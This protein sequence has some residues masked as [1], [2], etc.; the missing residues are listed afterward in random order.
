KLN[1][2]FHCAWLQVLKL[3]PSCAKKEF[4]SS[5]FA[6]V[7]IKRH[8]QFGPL[9]GERI[10]EA[11]ISEDTDLKDVWEVP[12]SQ[13]KYFVRTHS[14]NTSNWIRYLRPAPSRA[15][16]S[17]VAVT[18]NDHLFFVT[19][20]DLE[21][22]EEL[23]YWIDYPDVDITKKR[24]VDRA[25]CGTCNRS[26]LSPMYYRTHISI[27]HD[28]EYPLN[29]RKYHCKVC[30]EQVVGK[31]N[32][33]KHAEKLHDGKGAY[34]CQ[35]CGRF[36][37]R[38]SYLDVHRTYGCKNNPQRTRPL[39]DLCGKKFSQPQK[40]RTHV[41]RMHGD[42]AD[43][44][45]Q[46]QCKQ[47]SKLLGSGPALLRH[48]K[49][50]HKR[51]ID[52]SH[53]CEKCGK[54]FTNTSNL[55]IHMLTH[56]GIRPFLCKLKDC[57][58][59]FT[60]K[61]CLQQHYRKTHKLATSE[62]PPIDRVIPFTLDAY[63]GEGPEEGNVP[64]KSEPTMDDKEPLRGG[65]YPEPPLRAQ[66]PLPAFCR[67]EDNALRK[68]QPSASSL[69][70]YIA[71]YSSS[72]L[73]NKMKWPSMM[74]QAHSFAPAP[75]ASSTSGSE[76]HMAPTP[77]SSGRGST[78]DVYAF[79]EE[80]VDV[81]G[82]GPYQQ[83]ES[84]L[85]PQDDR[86]QTA[87]GASDSAM[88]DNTSMLIEAAL[89]AAG[90]SYP[91]TDAPNLRHN[92]DDRSSVVSADSGRFSSPS[93][94]FNNN[95]STPSSTSTSS[96]LSHSS[97]STESLLQAKEPTS[98]PDPC[99]VVDMR[100][101]PYLSDN[102]YSS[103]GDPKPAYITA[104]HSPSPHQDLPPLPSLSS[105][106]AENVL[107]GLGGSSDLSSNGHLHRPPEEPS[108]SSVPSSGI[109]EY[110]EDLRRHH[111]SRLSYEDPLKSLSSAFN[112]GLDL[113]RVSHHPSSYPFHPSLSS[114]ARYDAHRQYDL[115]TRT[116][117]AAY[118]MLRATA[119]DPTYSQRFPPYASHQHSSTRIDP[120]GTD[121]NTPRD[122]TLN[123]RSPPGR[124]PASPWGM[125]QTWDASRLG[126]SSPFS[127]THSSI[128]SMSPSLEQSRMNAAAAYSS[129]SPYSAPA[130][131]RTNPGPT[132][133][134][135]TGYY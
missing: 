75:E 125:H 31:E 112:P 58:K 51:N 61:Q 57:P 118:D 121:L 117:S 131:A 32:I 104:M 64:S 18:K 82:R 24:K 40:L 129:Y 60:T 88:N 30:S 33:I 92:G 134:Y 85:Q 50:V 87:V 47:C 71:K 7:S 76:A 21:D 8:T 99:G 93:I 5:V 3:E 133:G 55:K 74:E 79:K 19:I 128:P 86:T 101:K 15:E 52:S 132:H 111:Q 116:S 37:I 42:M 122:L 96:T 28:P 80:K 120:F 59:S 130:P 23:L 49:D 27:F 36:F 11:E 34:Q 69:D 123:N 63:A 38:L 2:L 22:G 105:A 124:I 84:P 56:S 106:S 72:K 113:G 107:Q 110:P 29:M 81:Q 109:L 95:S 78:E 66:E 108:V 41:K 1:S 77:G 89:T 62:M 65:P 54:T 94:P 67:E 91:Q 73:V 45:R 48:Y 25:A 53:A 90:A 14:E 39:C 115:S 135:Y 44:L 17:L 6:N 4:G 13:G 114:A 12:S 103:A 9:L 70:S 102:S 20:K 35:F 16:R 127:T 98:A 10:S 97:Y 68:Q 100:Y 26:F 119:V 46:F 43:V 126:P 83:M